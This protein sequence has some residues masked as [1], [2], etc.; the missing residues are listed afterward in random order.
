MTPVLWSQG[1]LT[2]RLDG[3]G[4]FLHR[5]SLE[6]QNAVEAFAAGKVVSKHVFRMSADLNNLVPRDFFLL[7]FM[8]LRPERQQ[9]VLDLPFSAYVILRT[10]GVEKC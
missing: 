8:K 2:P 4:S 9:K 7:S 5:L 6:V 1:R 10:I 3:I